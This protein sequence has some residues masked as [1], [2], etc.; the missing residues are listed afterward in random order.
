MNLHVI[1]QLQIETQQTGS[2][3]VYVFYNRPFKHTLYKP[4]SDR[5]LT[6]D[7]AWHERFMTRQWP[8]RGHGRA[9]KNTGDLIEKLILESQALRQSNIE[10]EL[11]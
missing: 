6:R 1:S 5:I 7:A 11:F 8:T 3:G 2:A 4:I 10:E 9:D